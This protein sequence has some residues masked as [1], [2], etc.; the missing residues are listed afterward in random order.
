VLV[1]SAPRTLARDTQIVVEHRPDSARAAEKQGRNLRI[2]ESELRAS[3]DKADPR[4]LF[5]LGNEYAQAGHARKAIAC[6][7][8]YLRVATWDDERYYAQTRLANLLRA[9]R[10][11]DEAVEANLGSLKICPHWPDAYFGMAE[12]YYHL[13]DWHKVVHW[14]EVGRAMP[15]PDTPLFVNPFDHSFNWVIFY[16]NALYHVGEVG[17]ALRWTKRALELRPD[18]AWHRENFLL[19]AAALEGGDTGDAAGFALPSG[20]A[21]AVETAGARV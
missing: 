4:L 10:R 21:G 6:Y 8:K 18:D 19:F 11:F 3:G 12:T 14:C 17:E 20:A 2:L 7:R 15:R 13:R 9:A 16:T 5:Y 1:P